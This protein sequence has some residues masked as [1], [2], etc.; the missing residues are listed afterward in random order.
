MRLKL[1]ILAKLPLTMFKVKFPLLGVVQCSESLHVGGQIYNFAL[2]LR[3]AFSGQSWSPY[4]VPFDMLD[5][6]SY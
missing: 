3:D 6:V 4:M 5:M 2:N 1:A